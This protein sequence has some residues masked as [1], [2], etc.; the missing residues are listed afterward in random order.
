MDQFNR[1]PNISTRK[2]P[3]KEKIGLIDSNA[4]KTFAD[5]LIKARSAVNK[6]RRVI[7]AELGLKSSV[8][9]EKWENGEAFPTEEMLPKIAEAYGVEI[10]TLI[11]A[12][13]ISKEARANEIFHLRGKKHS[14]QTI[15]AD[16]VWGEGGSRGGKKSPFK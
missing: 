11:E 9:I 15:N 5:V 8:M 14:S 1:L 16:P 6:S 10:N 2:T 13:K 12:Y 7:Q 4:V 3:D